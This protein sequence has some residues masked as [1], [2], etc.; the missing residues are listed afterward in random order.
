MPKEHERVVDRFFVFLLDFKLVYKDV[1]IS[2]DHEITPFIILQNYLFIYYTINLPTS[3]EISL[4][5]LNLF[6]FSMIKQKVR[7]P[8]RE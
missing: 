2:I 6:F 5:S 1:N 3:L 7:S 4:N 8:K